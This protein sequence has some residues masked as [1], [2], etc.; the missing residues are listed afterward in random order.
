M[1]ILL[2]SVVY[3]SIMLKNFPFGILFDD[4][5]DKFSG[6]EGIHDKTLEYPLNIIYNT[7]HECNLH[8][9]YCFRRGSGLP[10][11][12]NE[13]IIS[14]MKNLPTGKPLRLVLSGGEPFW[15]KDIYEV[16]DFCS[17]QP[18]EI[19]VVSNGTYPIDWK[20]VPKNIMFE[21]SIDAPNADIY[22]KTRGGTH[23]QYETLVKNVVDAVAHGHRVRPCYLM[24]RINTSEE[25]LKQII[26]FS[27]GLGVSELRLQRFKPWGGGEALAKNYEFS[28]KE[29]IDICNRAVNYANKVGIG[30]RVPQNNRF[31]AIGSIYVLPNGNV[32]IQYAD[33]K[34]QMVLGNLR[35]KSLIEIW[36]PFQE[37]FSKIHLQS[38]IR[39]KRIL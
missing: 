14:D 8:C 15:R 18:W 24:A 1:N 32:T 31:L 10:P 19:I 11:Q 2:E 9:Q 4:E 3:F 39:P 12:T 16:F 36:K 20:R 29:Y 28:Q 23:Q 6:P 37:K 5:T 13:E 26:D 27:K 22:G 21:F 17:R 38:L 25:I 30:V 7:S 34:E 35:K 33:K